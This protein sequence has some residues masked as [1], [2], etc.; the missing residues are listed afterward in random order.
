M[1]EE[2]D[3][4]RDGQAVGTVPIGGVLVARLLDE[5]AHQSVVQ[6]VRVDDEAAALAA[7]VHGE[8][9]R[10]DVVGCRGGG[11]LRLAGAGD[12][13]DVVHLLGGI[14]APC[15][16]FGLAQLGV[17]GPVGGARVLET[18]PL[19]QEIL[20]LALAADQRRHCAEMAMQRGESERTRGGGAQGR[21]LVKAKGRE[22]G[23][24][25]SVGRG[26]EHKRLRWRWKRAGER[27]EP[28]RKLG[29]RSDRRRQTRPPPHLLHPDFSNAPFPCP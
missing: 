9:A 19:A 11:I 1:L 10:R 29:K 27:R 20:D 15:G 13:V 25:G 24:A 2:H 3:L 23:K 4:A 22:A 7:D 12:V 5:A 16:G 6:V 8:V 18:L 26:G 14:E 17:H 21:L 28:G